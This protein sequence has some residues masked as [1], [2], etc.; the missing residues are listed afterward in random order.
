MKQLSD[1]RIWLQNLWLENCSEN[2]GWAQSRMTMAEYFSKYK[3][4]LRHEFRRQQK[5]D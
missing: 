2:D 3:H 5:N 4:W 1:F